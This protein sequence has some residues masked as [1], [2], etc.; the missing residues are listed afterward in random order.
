[1]KSKPHIDFRENQNVNINRNSNNDVIMKY[2]Y[3]SQKRGLITM[4]LR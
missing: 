3:Y 4:I 1:M 2:Y